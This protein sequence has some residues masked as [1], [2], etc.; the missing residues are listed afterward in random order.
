MKGVASI[1]VLLHVCS[2]ARSFSL[3]MGS[4]D[5]LYAEY[6]TLKIYGLAISLDTYFVLYWLAIGVG[7]WKTMLTRPCAIDKVEMP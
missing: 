2:F 5:M 3:L 4:F 7:F 1:W 6:V